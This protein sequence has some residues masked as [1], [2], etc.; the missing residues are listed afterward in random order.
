[1]T[2]SLKTWTGKGMPWPWHGTTTFMSSGMT[3]VEVSPGGISLTPNGDVAAHMRHP[4]QRGSCPCIT[5][6]T[7]VGGTGRVRTVGNIFSR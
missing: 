6:E 1:M 3:L 7:A 4:Q 2:V 5:G